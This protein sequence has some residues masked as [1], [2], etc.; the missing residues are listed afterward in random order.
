[1]K[2]IFR[3]S[4]GQPKLGLLYP[5]YSPDLVAYTDSDYAR[6][7]LDRKSTKGDSNE[8]KLIQM[9]KIHT[10][11][12][13]TN[14]LTK[15][16]DFWSTAK[17][18]IINEETQIHAL[19]HGKKIVITEST[20]RRDLQ[21]ADEDGIDC[22]LNTTIFENLALIGKPVAN[23]VVLKER[24]DSLERTATTASS[25]EAEQVSG[26]I[27]KTQS[28]AT[29]TEPSSL[30]TSSGGGPSCQETMGDI[31]AQTRS[32]NVSKLSNDPLL[33]RVKRLE[34]KGGSRIHKFNLLFK[35]GR[36]ARVISSDEASLGDQEDASKQGRKIDDIDTDEEITLVHETQER[37]SDDL[38]FDTGLFDD[39]GVSAGQDMDKKE[40]STTDTVITAGEVVTPASVEVSTA[41][42]LTLAQTLME[43]RSARP[44]AKGIVFREPGESTTTK[45]STLIPLKIQDKE[46]LE[47]E[48]RLARQKEEEANIA[49]I[50]SWDNI[51]STLFKQLLEARRKH[52][53]SMRAKEKRNKP[54]TKAQKRNTMSTYLKN[55]AGYKHTQLKNKSFDIQKL[56]Y[57]EMKRVNTFEDMNTELVEGEDLQQEST[58]KQKVDDDKEKEEFKQCFDIVLEEEVAIDA[59]PLATKPASIVDFKI[60]RVGK[61]GYYQIIRADGS[62]KMY[63][64]FSQ[65]LKSFDREDLETLW[66]LVK[67]KHGYTMP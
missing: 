33:G 7:S 1:M 35:V 57:K 18:K 52:F 23:K 41:N 20:V 47:E 42:D 4:K 32:E 19:V 15:A 2:R 61:Q 3:Y 58:K 6:A 65:L 45:I 59:I 17:A 36:S 48:E 11:K 38:M 13:V 66:R 49:L 50:E 63:L 10:D 14:L 39:K 26:N 56:F 31:I 24:G 8:K 40:V 46:E 53:A 67:A 16:F 12:N 51:Q 9:I 64:V 30:G 54:L 37:Y 28:K 5:K 44:K 29:P 55:M 60:H 21:L 62:S 25:L 22:L 34:K 43:I 27:T